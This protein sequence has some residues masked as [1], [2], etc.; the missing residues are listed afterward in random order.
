MTEVE[1]CGGGHRTRL[2]HQLVCLWGAPFPVYKGVEEGRAA[3]YGA[4]KGGVL[5]PVGVGF[6]PSLV[7]VGEEGRGRGR[8]GKGARP[9]PNSDWA[10]GAR[11]H[12]GRLLLSPTKAQ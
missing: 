1:I 5:L 4:P 9:P 8:E 11:P 10:W 6:L 12:L 3:L 7:G 2:N